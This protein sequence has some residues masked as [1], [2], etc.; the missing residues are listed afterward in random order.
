MSFSLAPRRRTPQDTSSTSPGPRQTRLPKRA[1]RF[2]RMKRL[3]K[4]VITP[5]R[6]HGR[7]A[8]THTSTGLQEAATPVKLLSSQ[9]HKGEWRFT[10]Q[11]RG[12]ATG[13]EEYT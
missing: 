12:R 6:Q 13:D 9:T 4:F 7:A 2:R 3:Q 8:N 5:I 10:L 1:P 11:D